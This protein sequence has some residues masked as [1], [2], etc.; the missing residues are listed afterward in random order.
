MED[1]RSGRREDVPEEV[2][3]LTETLREKFREFRENTVREP[4]VRANL[5]VS[6]LGD[7][8][9]RR[10]VLWSLAGDQANPIDPGLGMIF[11]MG[12]DLE[13]LIRRRLEDM[14]FKVERTQAGFPKNAYGISGRIDG[15]LRYRGAKVIVDFK[16]TNSEVFGS[17]G[18]DWR[19]L[20]I[21]PRKWVRKYPGQL[22]LYAYFDGGVEGA[23]LAFFDKG[24]GEMKFVAVPLDW[25]ICQDLLDQASRVRDHVA[26][27]TV[28][29]YLQ[30]DPVECRR[31]PF[32]GR[33]C[34][35]PL[36]VDAATVVTDE[37]FVRAIETR[38]ET[39][40]SS[41]IH[42]KADKFVKTYAKEA[43]GGAEGIIVAGRWLIELERKSKKAYAVPASSSLWVD[44]RRVDGDGSE[45]DAGEAGSE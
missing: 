41:K 13:P 8:C 33:V 22:I 14:G 21:H 15:E 2:A 6:S 5:W 31:C 37:E 12:N 18:E 32:F 29:G 34:D 1:G 30:G 17:I 4:T 7:P 36:T 28:P 25:G 38:F 27:E 26:G 24:T 11:Q 45:D 20:L 44:V 42:A 16:T 3:A 9:D 43:T 40:A 39:E 10:L 35:P 23:I 19:D